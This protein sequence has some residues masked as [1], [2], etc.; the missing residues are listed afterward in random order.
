MRRAP[1]P[2]SSPGEGELSPSPCRT[3]RDVEV[4]V[5]ED[6]VR[7]IEREFDKACQ[8]LGGDFKGEYS[9][10]QADIYLQTGINQFKMFDRR[11]TGDAGG[12]PIIALPE[13][14]DKNEAAF[15]VI[16]DF[17]GKVE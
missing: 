4:I 7:A 10:L 12:D 9:F 17:V 5:A 1:A 13:F 2:E 11:K 6:H 8:G 3:G 15:I 16:R 14:G